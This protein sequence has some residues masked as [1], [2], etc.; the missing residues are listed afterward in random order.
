LSREVHMMSFEKF[1]AS[2]REL[3]REERIQAAWDNVPALFGYTILKLDCDGRLI[4]RYEHGKFSTLG[5]EIDHVIPICVGGR[6]A[7]WN[8]RARHHLGNRAA[9]GALAGKFGV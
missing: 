8:V 6:D 5:W 2:G 7:P 1:A 4:S 3:T 9:G